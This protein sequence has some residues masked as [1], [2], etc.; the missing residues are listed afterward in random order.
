M[1]YQ[2]N[3]IPD[4]RPFLVFQTF[5]NPKFRGLVMAYRTNVKTI[6]YIGINEI[7]FNQ[8]IN[9]SIII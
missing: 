7:N 1:A 8:S 9:F 5:L 3:C 6:K 2:A 4:R